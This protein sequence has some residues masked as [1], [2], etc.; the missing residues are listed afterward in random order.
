VLYSPRS[1][2]Y[3]IYEAMQMG[4]RVQLSRS[5]V[6]PG[7]GS[8]RLNNLTELHAPSIVNACGAEVSRIAQGLSRRTEIDVAPYLLSLGDNA[9]GGAELPVPVALYA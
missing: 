1:G 9:R 3:L 8:V 2:G 7:S 4:A 6:F 5:V